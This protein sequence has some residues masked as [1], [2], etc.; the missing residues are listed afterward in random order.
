MAASFLFAIKG[1]GECRGQLRSVSNRNR[2]SDQKTYLCC[3]FLQSGLFVA[4]CCS[5]LSPAPPLPAALGRL[6][7]EREQNTFAEC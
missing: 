4:M 2:Q 3:N 6:V 5:G 1:T 7:L